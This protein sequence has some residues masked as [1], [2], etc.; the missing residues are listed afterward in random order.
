MA[1]DLLALQQQG[2]NFMLQQAAN[3]ARIPTRL[4]RAEA[5][6]AI[7]EQA[8]IQQGRQSVVN[9]MAAT[10]A[11]ILE[12]R[13]TY[14]NASS[15]VADVVDQY[16]ALPPGTVPPPSMIPKGLEVVA[17]V[18][19][20]TSALTE[21][22]RQVGASAKEVLTLQQQ[23]Q[24]NSGLQFPSYMSGQAK[25]LLTYA[26]IGGGI[27]LALIALGKSGGTRSF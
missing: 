2:I 20:V 21:I 17:V 13:R 8:A 27:Y 23:A 6:R 5:A 1:L 11:A 22:E 10:K 9:T 12:V 3:W 25:K 15:K 16:R 7:V 18:G 19:A 14:D 4:N 26:I 24:L